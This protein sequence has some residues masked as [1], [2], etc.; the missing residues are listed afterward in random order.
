MLY[1]GNNLNRIYNDLSKY[2]DGNSKVLIYLVIDFNSVYFD[3]TKLFKDIVKVNGEKKENIFESVGLGKY[4]EMPK[5]YFYM[6]YIDEES[7]KMRKNLL[8]SSIDELY[9]IF[10]ENFYIDNYKFYFFTNNENEIEDLVKKLREKINFEFLIKVLEVLYK[11]EVDNI[12]YKNSIL[13]KANQICKQTKDIYNDYD[14]LNKKLIEK[15]NVVLPENIQNNVFYEDGETKILTMEL[16]IKIIDEI[17]D[18]NL[19]EVEKEIRK[20][21][22]D[23]KWSKINWNI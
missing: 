16:V 22:N 2:I 4:Y 11:E 3:N 19:N 1:I 12:I 9:E 17:S 18:L 14:I 13:N 6:I 7:L 8:I 20:N 21:P 23:E 15:Y 5:N 10:L